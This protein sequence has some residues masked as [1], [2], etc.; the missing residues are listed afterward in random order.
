ML[1]SAQWPLATGHRA[2]FAIVCP[3]D[4]GSGLVLETSKARSCLLALQLTE[5]V[6]REPT[7]GPPDN[8]VLPFYGP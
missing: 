4:G 7:M 2:G 6:E 5:H 8:I 1:G 3:S